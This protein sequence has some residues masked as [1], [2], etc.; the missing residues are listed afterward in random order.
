MA[1]F[2]RFPAR[3][4]ARASA[5]SRAAKEVRSSAVTFADFARSV[6]STS[7]HHTAGMLCLCH[8][9]ETTVALTRRSD[10]MASL[11]GQSS[12]TDRNEVIFDMSEPIGQ[13]VLKSKAILSLDCELPLGHTVRMARRPLTDFECRFLARTCAARRLVAASQDE[14]APTLQDGM[15]QDHYKQYESRSPLPHE[16]IERCL[17]LTGV[18]YEWLFSGRGVGPAWQDRYQ[19]LL[20]K[21]QKAKKP[22]KAA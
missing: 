19:E 11:E 4:H 7:A 13:T 18:S 8:H 3:H 5:D 21:Q 15:K 12:T 10:A 17:W 1:T 16:L 14:F 22:Q 20:A 6:P 2:H 9:L